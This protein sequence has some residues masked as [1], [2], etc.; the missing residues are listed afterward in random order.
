[1]CEGTCVQRVRAI[2]GVLGHESSKVQGGESLRGRGSKAE[3]VWDSG[4]RA[5]RFKVGNP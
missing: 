1:M 4:L 3:M 5:A 2:V